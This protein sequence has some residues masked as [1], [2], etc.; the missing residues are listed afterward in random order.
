MLFV[1]V[2]ILIVL[3]ASACAL[4]A[5]GVGLRRTRRELA[6]AEHGARRAE[7]RA[8][9][10]VR[11][12]RLATHDI[13]G[14]GMTL[15]GHADHLAAAAHG[16]ADGIA[17][18]AADLLDLADQLQELTTD[19]AAPR[20]ISLERMALGQVA[21]EAVAAVS[22]AILPA[23]RNWRIQPGLR[24]MVLTADRRALRHALTRVLADA[25]RNT[26]HDDWIDIGGRL[27]ADGV[28]LSVADEGHGSL[29]P[30]ARPVRQDSRGIGLRLTLARTLVEAHGGRM[31]VESFA[32][33]GSRVTMVLPEAGA[34]P[35]AG[36]VSPP[37]RSYGVPAPAGGYADR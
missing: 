7:D 26:R 31:E 33:I 5:L 32:G 34:L 27:D 24:G 3:A 37:S 28:A 11:R 8:C 9:V 22:S 36:P 25:V 4:A 17:A 30:E 15:H 6:V 10:L 14:L 2:A 13:R 23:Q 20:V 19:P 18:G 29:T 35:K 21:D 1:T 12:L 16:T